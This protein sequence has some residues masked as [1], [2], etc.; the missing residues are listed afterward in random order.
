M[1]AKSTSAWS[2]RR[3]RLVV[4]VLLL[5][6]AGGALAAPADPR[7]PQLV[8]VAVRV[9]GT[10]AGDSWQLAHV[11]GQF[12]AAADAFAAWRLRLPPDPPSVVAGHEV[13]P[14]RG[15]VDW[16]FDSAT[17][18]LAIDASPGAFVASSLDGFSGINPPPTLPPPGAFLNYDGQWARTGSTDQVGATGEVGFFSRLGVFTASGVARDITGH[19]EYVRLATSFFRDDPATATSLRL[20]DAVGVASSWGRQVYFGGVQW[21]TKFATQPNLVLLPLPT[22]SGEAVAPSLVDVYVNNVL[23]ARREVLAGPFTLNQVPIVTGAGDV[24]MVVHDVLGREQVVTMNY[25]MSPQLLRQGLHEFAWEAGA[26]RENFGTVSNDYGPWFGA[27]AHRYGV[28]DRLTVEGRAE[29]SQRS[30]AV[31]GGAVFIVG[32]LG[33]V[34]GGA[35]GSTS[36]DGTGALG[37]V[38]AERISPTWSVGA[39]IEGATRTFRQ[40]GMADDE[41]PRASGTQVYGSISPLPNQSLSAGY[42]RAN[43]RSKGDINLA[44]I[45]YTVQFG[46]GLTAALTGFRSAIDDGRWGATLTLSFPLDARHF[47][48]GAA[49]R[50]GKTT[51][52]YAHLEQALPTDTGFGY[53]L[54]ASVSDNSGADGIGARILYQNDIGNYVAEVAQTGRETSLRVGAAGGIVAMGGHVM[55]SRVVQDSFA[56]VEVPGPA[57]IDIYSN[58]QQVT[59]TNDQGVALIPRLQAYQRN[60]VRVDDRGLPVEIEMD[61]AERII[62]PYARS[63][64]LVTFAA[65]RNNGAT[66]KIV[67]SDGTAIPLGSDVRID[68]A[69]ASYRVGLRGEVF[70]EEISYPAEVTVTRAG[71]E[72]RF[73]VPRPANDEPL[74][75]LG[76]FTC[77][78]EAP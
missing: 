1:P 60:V 47:L 39:R 28:T 70:V 61:L 68:G 42:I 45:G 48:S 75:R 14:L 15:L 63:G 53:D 18:T 4:A 19:S 35:V 76:P 24:K 12:Y 2:R 78:A 62:A 50:T 3:D 67:S 49:S 13:Y 74:P 64:V 56:M 22:L 73:A 51:Q 31:G 59:R 54:R 25:Y 41:M 33:T 29:V 43:N 66:L 37:Y 52:G 46:S 7:S 32:D 34:S 17:Q 40:V 57:G 58:N 36:P 11:D 71:N 10:A 30:A 8:I 5:C 72:C 27:T 9:N 44:T 38:Q 16:H 23:S 77:H 69:G 20:G 21:G 55:L 65:K 26:L 6:V